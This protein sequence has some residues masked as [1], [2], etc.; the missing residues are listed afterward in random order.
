MPIPKKTVSIA[1]IKAT[2]TEVTPQDLQ[3]QLR[4]NMGLRCKYTEIPE[5]VQLKN[6]VLD[7]WKETGTGQAYGVFI[8]EEEKNAEAAQKAAPITHLN[9]KGVNLLAHFGFS[10]EDVK[11]E[12]EPSDSAQGYTN[13]LFTIQSPANFQYLVSNFP[14]DFAGVYKSTADT[15]EVGTVDAVKN[16]FVK[17]GLEL[18][19]LTVNGVNQTSLQ[20][21]LY[22][23]LGM[24]QS[25]L[26]SDYDEGTDAHP[27]SRVIYLV[28][29]YNPETREADAIGV[30][31]IDWALHIS[32]YKEK[33]KDVTHTAT[34]KL[35]S[36]AALYTNLDVMFRDYYRVLSHR[37]SLLF[38][39]MFRL[40]R[41][42][43]RFLITSRRPATTAFCGG[44]P[45]WASLPTT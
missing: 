10:D 23:A 27:M 15:R 36:R 21:I 20:P 38:A 7:A 24:T 41:K 22:K 4:D 8:K 31:A 37:K 5:L 34:L 13:E 26:N 17:I 42:R 12:W 44:F 30:L 25:S 45:L 28:E 43:S 3:Q 39:R 2:A 29:N 14:S 35:W 11:G 19:S 1:L 32:N 33:K 6:E 9:I 40:V 16:F 18:A